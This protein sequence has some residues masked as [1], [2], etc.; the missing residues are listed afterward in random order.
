MGARA[1]FRQQRLGVADVLRAAFRRVGIVELRIGAH[2]FEEVLQRPGKAGLLHDRPHLAVQT[3][4]LLQTQ[5]V[6][7]VR[8]H[9]QGRVV[10]QHD[11]VV[12]LAVRQLPHAGIVGRDRLRRLQVRNQGA[13]AG[14][15][16]VV[17]GRQR[18]RDQFVALGR[19]EPGLRDLGL[20]VGVERTVLR[21]VV[22]G[23][24]GD[25]IAR[26]VDGQRKD[27]LRRDDALQLLGL[28]LDDELLHQRLYP[29]QARHIGLGVGAG[30]DRVAVLQGD[31]NA[32]VHPAHLGD[33]IIVPAPVEQPQLVLAGQF[34][35]AITELCLG[36]QARNVEPAQRR[37][38]AAHQGRVGH[39]V[40]VGDVIPLVV[41]V[42]EAEPRLADRAAHQVA[43]E[44]RLEE[45][46][47]LCAL[48]VFR[49]SRRANRGREQETARQLGE[50]T[51]VDR[52]SRDAT[53]A[54]HWL[55][56][57]P[58]FLAGVDFT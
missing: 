10:L 17:Q 24:A 7:F 32:R 53:T 51:P 20:E 35:H 50:A 47:E 23:L 25:H 49:K 9:R 27:E 4:D 43:L 42:A 31:G 28:Q 39:A 18:I 30:L 22:E 40:R 21:A 45:G 14:A 29:M 54:G 44:D 1:H 8:R 26:G 2:V 16:A 15:H 5:R 37:E 19:R 3:V 33:Q 11:P 48:V 36:V 6:Q 13:V 46:V 57:S 58:S 56:S 12:G 52:A 41:V 34:E 38:I 55:R